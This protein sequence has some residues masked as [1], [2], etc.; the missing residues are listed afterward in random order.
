MSKLIKLSNGKKVE[1]YPVIP[2][3]HLMYY[4]SEHHSTDA[5]V[6]NIVTGYYW[7]GEFDAALMK[8]ALYGELSVI[9]MRGCEDFANQVD[10][11]LIELFEGDWLDAAQIYRD[12][13][14]K[15]RA[16]KNKTN[17]NKTRFP[18]FIF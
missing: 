15:E 6:L 11:G 7:Q 9:G 12:W 13:F 10:K 2:A 17:K 4:L 14:E 8:E 3:Q 16:N 5:L 18:G 1:G